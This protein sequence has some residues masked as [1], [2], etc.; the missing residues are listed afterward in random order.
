M[1]DTPTPEGL[2]AKL[3]SALTSKNRTA[4]LSVS[5]IG[6]VAFLVWCFFGTTVLITRG[7]W[8]SLYW[9]VML[10]LIGIS[11]G[12]M[13]R[14]IRHDVQATSNN[15]MMAAHASAN[16][17]QASRHTQTA[18]QTGK[19]GKRAAI[20][21]LAIPAGVAVLASIVIPFTG[22][23]IRGKATLSSV[24]IT[25]APQDTY[26]WRTP[27]VVA[28]AAITS[29]AGSVVGTF[30]SSD[31][32]Y[33]PGIDGYSTPIPQIGFIT[34]I[35][36]VA[37][38]PQERDNATVCSFDGEVPQPGGMFQ[39]N[40]N[41]ALAFVNPALAGDGSDA[42]TYCD[43]THA[44]LVQPVT[45]YSGLGE[46][47]KV[48]AGIVV[49]DGKSAQWIKNVTA[50][51]YPGPVYPMSLAAAQRVSTENS[52][53]FSA[54]F[55]GSAGYGTT[56]DTSGDTN[57]GNVSELLLERADGHGYD[58]VT[59]L[60][61]AGQSFSI[62]AVSAVSADNVTYGQFNILTIHRLTNPRSGDTLVADRVKNDFPALG[63][64]SGL[65]LVEV[66]PLS[67]DEWTGTLANNGA[68]SQR[69]ILKSDGTLC[70]ADLNGTVS[71]CVDKNNVPLSTGTTSDNPTPGS[72][73]PA[74]GGSST[75]GLS[76][77]LTDLTDAQLA[78]LQA[79]VSDEITRRLTRS[80]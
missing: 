3:R 68:V 63:W 29:K 62:V 37:V 34:G 31:T 33:L 76:T 53:D 11:I 38:L 59:P 26:Q 40:L 5:I 24:K 77:N 74:T 42:W 64:A 56:E 54:K 4:I 57:Q 41:R 70:L 55:F 6:A 47:H 60:T 50:G 36:K 19:T 44:K 2:R 43:G 80:K 21:T 51:T 45:T 12:Y 72:S 9:K 27:W 20:R 61:P 65:T 48:P 8:N 58:F 22:G 7:I 69:V 1:T 75:T 67:A 49:F 17:P 14:L 71:T 10:I 25:N 18:R 66:L 15:R 35:Y 52:L 78:Q 30:D 28:S 16:H 32:T 79:K 73:T 46:G 13:Q 39:Y 23:W